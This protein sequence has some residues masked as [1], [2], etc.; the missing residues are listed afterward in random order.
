M[1]VDIDLRPI[2]TLFTVEQVAAMIAV[3]KRT[4]WRMLSAKETIQRGAALGFRCPFL[5]HC[6]VRAKPVLQVIF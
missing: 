2:P 6:S 1:S 3:S 4:V 5:T